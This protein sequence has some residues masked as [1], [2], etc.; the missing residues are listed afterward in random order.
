MLGFDEKIDYLKEVLGV[1]DNDNYADSFK[2]DISLF[3]G[4]FDMLNPKMIFLNKLSSRVEI[5]GWIDKLTSRIVMKFDE[6][7]ECIDDF[8]FDYMEFG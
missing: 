8:I 6:D 7:N 5:D 2:V 3:I 4:D 1:V